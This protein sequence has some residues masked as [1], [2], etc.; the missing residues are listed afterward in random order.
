MQVHL[1][2]ATKIM[3]L[4]ADCRR[5]KVITLRCIALWDILDFRMMKH[6]KF[7]KKTHTQQY[8]LRPVIFLVKRNTQRFNGFLNDVNLK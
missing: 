6:P 4:V 1:L 7:K 2:Q 3:W 8:S 5:V